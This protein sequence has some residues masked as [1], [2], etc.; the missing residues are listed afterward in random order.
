MLIN[1]KYN[2]IFTDPTQKPLYLSDSI[3]RSSFNSTTYKIGEPFCR[4]CFI[5]ILKQN[6]ILNE[7]FVMF[8][9]PILKLYEYSAYW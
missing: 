8:R 7:L 3:I 5:E 4:K 1:L 2:L 6:T 9:T